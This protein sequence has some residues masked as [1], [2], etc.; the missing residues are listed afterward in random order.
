MALREIGFDTG[1]NTHLQGPTYNALE[2]PS[3]RQHFANKTFNKHLQQHH[4]ID[5]T[6]RILDLDKH[7]SKLRI[8]DQEFCQSENKDPL[9]QSLPALLANSRPSSAASRTYSTRLPSP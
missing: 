2:D 7:K 3:L 9:F 6:G 4:L 8:I 5:R 1:G